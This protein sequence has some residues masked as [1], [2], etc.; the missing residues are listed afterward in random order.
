MEI[1]SNL[2]FTAVFIGAIAI[3]GYIS[4]RRIRERQRSV[5]D[6]FA[7]AL[8]RQGVGD[9]EI[10]QEQI[11]PAS[12]ME[13]LQVRRILRDSQGNHYLYIHISDSPGVLRPLTRERAL[14][15]MGK[16]L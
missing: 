15:A 1:A 8:K 12:L 16:T 13:L 11:T 6:E 14:L 7:A 3:T 2:L 4:A 9:H 10:L 5:A